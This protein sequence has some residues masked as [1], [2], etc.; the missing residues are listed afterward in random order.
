MSSMN[1]LLNMFFC[2]FAVDQLLQAVLLRGRGDGEPDNPARVGDHV[3]VHLLLPARHGLRQDDRHL[4]CLQP[5]S[6]LSICAP[7]HSGG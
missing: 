3:P 5:D 1:P 2:P 4:A 6:A 7:P